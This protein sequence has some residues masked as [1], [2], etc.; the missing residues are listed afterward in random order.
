MQCIIQSK[1]WFSTLF[2]A[3]RRRQRQTRAILATNS[4]CAINVWL[5]RFILVVAVRFATVKKT[6]FC[7]CFTSISTKNVC[8]WTIRC[9]C[10]WFADVQWQS[11][12]RQCCVSDTSAD[13]GTNAVTNAG[14]YAVA[15]PCAY[16]MCC[17]IRNDLIC[18]FYVF[19]LAGTDAA[20]NSN[21]IILNF[22]PSFF[23]D[24]HNILAWQRS[25][26]PH[27]TP[28]VHATP[29]PNANNVPTQR[30][31]PAKSV[32]GV[33]QAGVSQTIKSVVWL[34]N[35]WRLVMRVPHRL[36]HRLL[37]T[38]RMFNIDLLVFFF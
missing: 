22:F 30:T 8:I 2:A 28:T 9:V 32:A 11:R 25:R 21:S 18:S 29:S 14:T 19:F 13:A 24:N 20:T 23:L 34:A 16:G 27:P 5:I 17:A 35:R 36:P 4:S 31:T 1:L 15:H 33:H 37:F 7:V 26:R 38:R 6:F 12:S 3:P 10:R